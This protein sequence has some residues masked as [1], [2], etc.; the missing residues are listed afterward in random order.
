ML[1]RSSREFLIL[2]GQRA[3]SG[4]FPL[5]FEV[6]GDVVVQTKGMA[7]QSI[8]LLSNLGERYY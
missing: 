8:Y 3:D 4:M 6:L 1:F 5:P 7:A 2:K